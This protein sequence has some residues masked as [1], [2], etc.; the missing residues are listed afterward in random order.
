MVVIFPTVQEVV[1]GVAFIE[2]C[3]RSSKKNGAWTS[4]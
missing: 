4:L 3:V 1:E 2:A